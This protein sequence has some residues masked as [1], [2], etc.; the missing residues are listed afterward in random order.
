MHATSGYWI[1][2][3]QISVINS[4]INNIIQSQANTYVS[5]DTKFVAKFV[6]QKY[7]TN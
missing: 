1:T 7:S 5:Y 2:F 6:L 3:H 4:C